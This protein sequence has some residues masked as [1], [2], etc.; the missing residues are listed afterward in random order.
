M[1]FPFNVRLSSEVLLPEVDVNKTLNTNIPILST[2]TKKLYAFIEL[3]VFVSNFLAFFFSIMDA[4]E[5]ETI[6]SSANSS[7]HFAVDSSSSILMD[8]PRGQGARC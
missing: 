3:F 5:A 6:E 2:L 1:T 7:R 4:H 8:S